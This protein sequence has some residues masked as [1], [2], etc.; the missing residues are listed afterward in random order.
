MPQ[1][2]TTKEK[3]LEKIH[4]KW[5]S[6]AKTAIINGEEMTVL[7]YGYLT[8]ACSEAIDQTREEPIK[9]VKDTLLPDGNNS[10]FIAD[11]V[12][13]RQLDELLNH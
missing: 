11:K 6:K 5:L 7:P 2:K 12:I 8:Q 3:L 1:E 10:A 9:E 4:I 13:R